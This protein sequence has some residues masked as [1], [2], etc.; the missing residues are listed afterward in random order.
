MVLYLCNLLSNLK[1]QSDHEKTIR[2]IQAGGQYK[3]FFTS[4]P[5]N[6]QSCQKQES[7]RNYHS[8]EEFKET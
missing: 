7:L 1:P 3:K 4:T 2:Q 6:Y 8:Q 5:Q